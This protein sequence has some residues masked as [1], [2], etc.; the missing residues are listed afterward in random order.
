MDPEK[1]TFLPPFT[2]LAYNLFRK[3]CLFN[4]MMVEL[5]PTFYFDYGERVK[6]LFGWT[7]PHMLRFATGSDE[8]ANLFIVCYDQD[9]KAE[10]NDWFQ[11][12]VVNDNLS[13]ED[14]SFDLF[15]IYEDDCCGFEKYSKPE[16]RG[17]FIMIK[18]TMQ[19]RKREL[20]EDQDHKE[21]TVEVWTGNA[22]FSKLNDTKLMY[23]RNRYLVPEILEKAKNK[24]TPNHLLKA[25]TNYQET[26]S[27]RD[28]LEKY[29]CR[30]GDC[31]PCSKTLEINTFFTETRKHGYEDVKA[32]MK[33]H[34]GSGDDK[35]RC[36]CCSRKIE[37]KASYIE[38][39][40][41]VVPSMFS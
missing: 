18:P 24:E 26:R 9:S 8:K 16:I 22:P 36:T 25:K 27:T 20:R 21:E 3:S 15:R 2:N 6:K 38:S 30:T 7:K 33:N 39:I 31:K 32:E 1:K 5:F 13:R 41:S 10:I 34:D 19:L 4:R 11:Y 40:L 23:Q 37:G 28:L 29:A 12:T 14:S 17:P 35:V